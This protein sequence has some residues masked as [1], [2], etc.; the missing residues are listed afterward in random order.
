MNPK[1]NIYWWTG[2]EEYEFK[3][4]HNGECEACGNETILNEDNICEDCHVIFMNE[5][6]DF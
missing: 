1:K 5:D 3:D 6:E 2:K 4:D